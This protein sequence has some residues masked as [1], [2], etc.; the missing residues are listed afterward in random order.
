MPSPLTKIKSLYA[1]FSPAQKQL[2]D[3]VLLK[4]GEEV[5]FLT[6]RELARATGV[7][8]ASISRFARALE[9]ESF[10]EFKTQLGRESLT[11][12]K[13]MYRAIGP[14]DTDS[15]IIE[16]VFTG[17]IRS[18]EET[19][20]ILDRAELVRA[21]GMLAKATR[22]VFFGMG[23]SGNIGHDAALRF[24]QLDIQ[25]EAYSD[26][27]QMLNQALR[28][29]KGQLAVGISTSGRSATTVEAL[30]LA[31]Q[32]KAATIGISNCLKSP[33]HKVS[34]IFFCTSFPESRVTVAAL[35]PLVAQMCLVDAMYLLVVRQ[36]KSALGS[37][38][39]MNTHTEKML[40]LPTR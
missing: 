17:N 4:H 31:A 34:D 29:K 1:S 2:A 20:K 12:V 27:Y 6:V 28:M 25:A 8:V 14:E 22:L 10:K 3:Y 37:A 21:A 18:L 16:K 32:G 40:R 30:Q 33:L 9:Y 24:S 39:R 15:D 13:S 36:K 23:S 5:P 7:S 11:A 38:E 35:S 26:S 19:L